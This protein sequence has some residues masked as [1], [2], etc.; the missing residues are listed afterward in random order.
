VYFVGLFLYIIENARS[1]KQNS[2]HKVITVHTVNAQGKVKVYEA[3]DAGQS[4]ASRSGRSTP[5]KKSP[6]YTL[7]RGL[8]GF[9]SRFRRFTEEEDLLLLKRTET[10]S[11]SRPARSIA[12]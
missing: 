12:K 10:K 1:K 8:G 6:R 3:P 5:E 9:Q 2:E 4:S 11:V 7:H